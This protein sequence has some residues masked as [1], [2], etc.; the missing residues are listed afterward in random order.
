MLRFVDV[1]FK[2]NVEVFLQRLQCGSSRV[3]PTPPHLV[4]DDFTLHGHTEAGE[5]AVPD[6]SRHQT[7]AVFRFGQLVGLGLAAVQRLSGD[8]ADVA[9]PARDDG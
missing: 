7:L 3:S 4:A 2:N 8:E 1:R 6:R 5:A 9:V